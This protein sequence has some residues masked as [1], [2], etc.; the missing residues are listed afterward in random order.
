M[1]DLLVEALRRKGKEVF[2][3]EQLGTSD[4]QSIMLSCLVAL[5]RCCVR[6]VVALR[7]DN[8]FGGVGLIGSASC[9]TWK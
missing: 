9:E 5:H 7:H 6:V 1:M 4:P 2:E 8:R 3:K